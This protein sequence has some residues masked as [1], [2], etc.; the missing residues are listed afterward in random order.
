MNSSAKKTTDTVL[1]GLGLG[2]WLELGLLGYLH[3][4]F[5]Y[6]VRRTTDYV[7][8][9]TIFESGGCRAG[10]TT[11]EVPTTTGSAACVAGLA[12]ALV[13]RARDAGV[14]FHWPSSR[15]QDSPS[16][17]TEERAY[18]QT[19]FMHH[20]NHFGVYIMLYMYAVF[21][22]VQIGVMLL[23]VK[24]AFT[25]TCPHGLYAHESGSKKVHCF[26]PA[27]VQMWATIQVALSLIVIPA[28][29]LAGRLL[30]CDNFIP[31]IVVKLPARAVAG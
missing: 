12:L 31:E 6:I 15:S 16:S 17:T 27:Y 18:N 21:A 30:Y 29:W 10:F 26:G 4:T 14:T 28:A 7:L 23:Q 9:T 3:A 13:R 25:D 22:L 24:R 8:K 5:A 11:Q 1:F 20:P 2:V 19:T